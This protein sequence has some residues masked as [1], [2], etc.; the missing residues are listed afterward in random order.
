MAKAFA[1]SRYNKVNN[2]KT[3]DKFDVQQFLSQE[4]ESDNSESAEEGMRYS[5]KAYCDKFFRSVT[6]PDM[7]ARRAHLGKKG[8]DIIHDRRARR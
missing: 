4:R 7:A 5:L 1:Q 2:V 6:F 3:K 8:I